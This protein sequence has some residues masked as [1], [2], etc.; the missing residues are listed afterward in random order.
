MKLSDP[1][2]QLLSIKSGLDLTQSR[3]CEPLAAKIQ[4]SCQQRISVTTLRRLLGFDRYDHEPYHYT[5]DVIAQ[6]IG[7]PS[8]EH[9]KADDTGSCVSGFAELQQSVDSAELSAGQRLTICYSP[10]RQL[11]LTYLGESRYR[12]DE[13]VMSKLQQGDLLTIQTFCLGFPLI[14]T[15]VER[16][17][18][19]PMAYTAARDKGLERIQLL[20]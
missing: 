10:G 18:M 15:R 3:S 13:S 17:G 19:E 7:Y 20:C 12:V 6:Y 5:L 16:Q 1:I 9:L 4:Q 14:V 8:W 11:T 2:I